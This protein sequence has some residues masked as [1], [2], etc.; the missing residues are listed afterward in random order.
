MSP[1]IWESEYCTINQFASHCSKTPSRDKSTLFYLSTITEFQTPACLHLDTSDLRMKFNSKITGPLPLVLITSLISYSGD[2]HAQAIYN[3]P[4]SAEATLEQCQKLAKD[5]AANFQISICNQTSSTLT[6][7]GVY[8]KLYSWKLTGSVPPYTA[9]FVDFN[10]NDTSSFTNAANFAVGET[11]KFFQF[12]AAWP[13]VG[14]SKIQ[15]CTINSPGNLPA[16]NCWEQTRNPDEKNVVNGSFRA[17]GV[18]N[19][20]SSGKRRWAFQVR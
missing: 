10:G 15:I 17:R 12:G 11:G 3:V 13:P 7:S 1:L 16:E 9:Q 2:A 8:N 4:I 6:F 18:L 19:Q 5:V 14:R 20:N